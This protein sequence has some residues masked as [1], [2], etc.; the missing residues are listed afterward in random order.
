MIQGVLGLRGLGVYNVKVYGSTALSLQD[1]RAHRDQ[2]FPLLVR[3][4]AARV[5]V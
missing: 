4:I 2:C 1:S 5:R 3:N